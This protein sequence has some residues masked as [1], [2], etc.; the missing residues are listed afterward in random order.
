MESIVISIQ[1][2]RA[3]VR[4]VGLNNLMDEI[5]N[6]I[7]RA[8]ETYNPDNL[9]TSDRDGFAYEDPHLGLL[10]WMPIMR[11]GDRVTI[12]VVGYHPQ[13]P[14]SLNLPTI[15]ST[16]S[17]Y[18]TTNGHLDGLIDGTLVTAFRTGAASAIASRLMAHPETETVGLIGCGA[19]ALTQLHA[20]SRIFSIKQVLIYDANPAVSG[21]FAERAAVLGL[22]NA[23][24]S[25]APLE[26]LLSSSDL[27]CTSTS[28][29]VGE[30]PV[31]EDNG[32]KPWI[33][34]NAVGSD[35]QGK[36]ELPRSLLKRS[37]VCP[38]YKSQ[39]IK[40]GE[41]QQLEPEEIGP[42]LVDLV[43][44]PAQ[45]EHIKQ[46]PSVFDSTG[47]AIEDLITA[48]I[49]FKHAKMLGLGQLMQIENLSEDPR[50]P[51][52]FLGK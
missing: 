23:K 46:R 7:C 45:Y 19:H 26:T 47:W 6:Q 8:L 25:I 2:T 14:I 28:I 48:D 36:T 29:G 32:L 39:A 10:E 49:F 22:H 16:I 18:D 17:V 12:K 3:V 30:G 35:F 4:R 34:I 38:D 33:H 41:C 52:H 40:E 1:D 5:I 24:I 37:I 43:Q 13:N 31:F 20:L 44:N 11:H 50:N 9:V 15:I 51:Y 42:G 21:S 27:I